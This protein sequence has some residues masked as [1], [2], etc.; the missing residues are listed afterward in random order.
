[1]LGMHL[2]AF[3]E[4]KHE[5]PKIKEF[6]TLF[7]YNP[8]QRIKRGENWNLIKSKRPLLHHGSFDRKKVDFFIINSSFVPRII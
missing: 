2:K 4:H 3:I 8:I 5:Y 1:M 6:C 7:L